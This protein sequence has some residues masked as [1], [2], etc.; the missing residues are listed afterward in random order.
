[1]DRDRTYLLDI[2][3][4]ARLAVRYLEGISLEAFV[5][6]MQ[7][8]DA[9]VRRLEIMGEAAR[10]MSPQ[11]K[12]AKPDLPWREMAGLRNLLIHEYG[13][14]DMTLVWQTVHAELPELIRKLQ[15]MTGI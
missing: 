7:L 15:D 12:E 4:A 2:L 1:M 13:A 8:Q 9:V 10:R 6:N 14:V 11:T 5:S 3:D